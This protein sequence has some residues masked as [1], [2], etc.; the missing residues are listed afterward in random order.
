MTDCGAV[1]ST[2]QSLDAC[3]ARIDAVL[4]LRTGSDDRSPRPDAGCPG[5]RS[6]TPSSTRST[7]H[8]L[9][10]ADFVALHDHFTDAQ[11]ATL[12]LAVAMFDARARFATALEV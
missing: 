4:R 12:T 9:R 10:D 7:P 1:V 3:Q 8:G 2:P 5:A 11:L 6:P